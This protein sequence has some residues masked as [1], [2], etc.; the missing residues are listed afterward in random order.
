[1]TELNPNLAVLAP[2]GDLRVH[3]KNPRRIDKQRFAALKASLRADPSMLWQRPLG[4]RRDGVVYMGNMRLRAAQDLGWSHVPVVYE[5][6]PEAEEDLRRL[7]DNQ[8]YGEDVAEEVAELLYGLQ[9][10][11]ADLALSGYAPDA[12]NALLDSVSGSGDLPG[13]DAADLEP[14]AEPITKPGDL[15]LLGEHR[16]LCG[17]SADPAVVGRLMAGRKAALMTTDPPYGVD[18]ASLVASRKNQKA[19][20]WDD[21][22]NDALDDDALLSLLTAALGG[23]GATTA[24]VWHP[25]GARRFLFWR[26]LEANDW[27]IAQEIVWVKNALVFGRADYQWR[28]EPCLYA[29]KPGAPAQGDRTQTTVWEEAKT[30]HAEHPTQ[31]PVGLYERPIKNHTQR[32]DLVYDPFL[33][34]GTA[35]IAAE[36]LGRVCYGV[37]LEP[38][39]CDV[40]VRRWETL[41]GKTATLEGASDGRDA[42]QNPTP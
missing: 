26:A 1:M 5:D 30:T 42:Q 7:R 31:K 36:G 32:G 24:F 3:P 17:D 27:R 37:E 34:S 41:T 13:A 19:G 14:P 38:R 18:Y 11:G 23:A 20:G 2:I 22:H 4:A 12:V 8:G 21:I 40:I 15:W 39:Y 28:H 16:L 35:L 9:Q 25:A 29:K 33:G 10:A 6:L